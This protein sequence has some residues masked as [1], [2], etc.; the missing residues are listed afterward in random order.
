[1]DLKAAL[2]I[3]GLVLGIV[4]LVLAVFHSY[5]I[6]KTAAELQSVSET[7]PTR[8]IGQFPDYLV[9]IA[10]VVE[11]AKKSVCVL[12]DFPAYGSFSAPE[13]FL[14]YRQALEQLLARR[15]DDRVSVTL[16]CLI[17]KN[18]VEMIKE[19]FSREHREWETWKREAHPRTKLER[20][21]E[22]RNRAT[23]VDDLSF[24]AFVNYLEDEDLRAI[25]GMFNGAKIREVDAYV[26]LYFWLV[27]GKE[28]IFALPSFSEGSTEYGFYTR[29]SALIEGLVEVLNRYHRQPVAKA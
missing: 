11:R 13:A 24:D 23:T 28:A 18:R 12:C 2:E 14:Q 22:L 25:E 27:D 15:N 7:L 26:P 10:G 16:T 21:I 4:A 1:M 9:H 29:D 5:E 3:I 17:G 20:L 19:Q 6:R 8:H